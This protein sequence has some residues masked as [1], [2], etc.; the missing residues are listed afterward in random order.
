MAV[1]TTQATTQNTA[2]MLPAINAWMQ[3]DPAQYFQ[4][5]TVAGFTPMQQQAWGSQMQGANNIQQAGS[6]MMGQFAQGPQQLGSQSIGVGGGMNMFNNPYLQNSIQAGMQQNNQNFARNVMPGITDQ[7][8]SQPGSARSG[9]AQGLAMG[10]LNQQNLNMASQMNQQAYDQGMQNHL[11]QRNQNIGV[12]QGNQQANLSAAQG[13]QQ[14][15]MQQMGMMPDMMNMYGQSQMQP[16]Q[17]MGDI[18]SQ[19]QGMNQAQIGAAQDRWNFNQNAAGDKLQSAIGMITG[20]GAGNFGSSSSN[21]SGG[22][23]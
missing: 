18:G 2:G 14:A 5:N 6:G 1:N 23:F 7:Y 15:G 16:G 17:T 4:G 8:S 3:Q 11:N 12:L 10:D 21:T 19:Q 9:I 20:T 22:K 13:N